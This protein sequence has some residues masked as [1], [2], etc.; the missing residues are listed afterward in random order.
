MPR[1][2]PGAFR[3]SESQNAN[4][5]A[6]CYIIEHGEELFHLTGHDV[7]VTVTGLPM[8]KGTN[9][10]VF[11]PANI[12]HGSIE[13]S[14]E[15]AQN[16]LQVAV[17]I[18]QGPFT[19]ELRELMLFTTPKKTTITVIRV[20][21][22]ALPNIAWGVDTYVMFK[23]VANALRFGDDVISINVLSLILQMRGQIPIWN[24][25]K[26]CQVE[27]GGAICSLNIDAD[28]YRL[29]TT[30]A[31]VNM[32]GRYIDIAD[33][34]LDSVPITAAMMQGGKIWEVDETP[35]N[36]I[37]IHAAEVLPASAGTRLYLAWWSR[38]L[39]AAINVK[40]FRGCNRTLTQCNAFG[41]KVNFRNYP[42][43]PDVS[44]SIHGVK[45]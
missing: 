29:E 15:G 7:P 14:A 4:R 13:Q 10:Q 20:S 35:I 28:P 19:A 36:K 39:A 21:S 38:T 43:I 34:T 40:V 8:D 12:K 37:T 26:T 18:N 45:A 30:V 11:T 27:F 42:W 44:P 32:R 2:Q 6:Y 41:N 24:Y 23:G 25:Q 1:N 31:A 17:G 3:S 5:K 16:E 9:P 22:N 33:T